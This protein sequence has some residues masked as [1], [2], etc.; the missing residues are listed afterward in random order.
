MLL[1]LNVV[2]QS[3]RCIVDEQHCATDLT[4]FH[5]PSFVHLLERTH[6]LVPHLPHSGATTN[7]ATHNTEMEIT[8]LQS[9]SAPLTNIKNIVQ[10][11]A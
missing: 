4:H 6:H 8:S 5:R 7:R 2:V 10:I 11:D 1:A 9:A 3:L